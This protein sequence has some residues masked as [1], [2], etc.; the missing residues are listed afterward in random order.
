MAEVVSGSIISYLGLKRKNTY[1]L[2]HYA[3]YRRDLFS[4]WASCCQFNRMHGAQLGRDTVFLL[5]QF[6]CLFTLRLLLSVR[7]FLIR[8]CTCPLDLWVTSFCMLPAWLI[9]IFLLVRND[10][11]VYN[12]QCKWGGQNR[13]CFFFH[14]HTI[15]IF[16]LC[17]NK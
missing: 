13:S 12:S 6:A 7:G 9:V 3:F 8:I 2:Y 17:H 14:D 5:L 4:F 10:P 11:S 1:K 16:V 15:N